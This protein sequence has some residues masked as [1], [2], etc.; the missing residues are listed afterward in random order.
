MRSDAREAAFKIVF[1]KL[2]GGDCEEKFR[3]ALYK[4]DK[5]KE[6]DCAFSERLFSLVEEHRETFLSQIGERVERFGE[7][8]IYY[9]DKAIMLVALAE[10]FYCDDVPN[11]VAVSEATNLARK[12]SAEHSAEFVNGVLGGFINE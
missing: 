12:Y 8:R 2:F 6:E 7:H 11:V 10:I 4:K 5:L 3:T 9:A 1:A